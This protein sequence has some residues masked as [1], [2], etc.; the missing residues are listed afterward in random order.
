MN[1]DNIRRIVNEIEYRLAQQPHH[2]E[3]TLRLTAVYARTMEG[4][5]EVIVQVLFVK[6][7]VD[8]PVS[9][10]LKALAILDVLIRYKPNLLS[11]AQIERILRTDPFSRRLGTNV[12]REQKSE[13]WLTRRTIKVYIMR[14]RE[15][16]R[17]TLKRAG[18]TMQPNE[19]LVSEPTEL[20][21]VVAYRIDIPCEVVHFSVGDMG[22]SP[23]HR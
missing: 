6:G 7:R 11:A 23:C 4:I 20:A 1:S 3:A 21:N 9:L 15:Q 12:P 19:V 10:G 13:L 14:L 2:R 17:K 8:F 5:G 18:L 16:L 22:K